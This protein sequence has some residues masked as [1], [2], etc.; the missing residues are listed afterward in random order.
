MLSCM[1][2]AVTGAS[3]HVGTNLCR[4]LIQQGHQLKA[5]VYRNLKG[6]EQLPIEFIKGDI[7]REEDLVTLC[8]DW[9]CFF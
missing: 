2:I 7:T 3:G 6:I 9:Q 1:K 8:R 4:M 5:L